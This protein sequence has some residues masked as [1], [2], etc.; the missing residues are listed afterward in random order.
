MALTVQEARALLDRLPRAKLGYFPTPLMRLDRLSEKLGVTVYIKRDDCSGVNLFGG[1]KVRKLEYL[2]GQALRDGATHAVTYGATQSNHAMETAWAC[3][4]LGIQPILYLTAVV[5][6]RPEEMRANL[7]LDHIL[8][9]EIHIVPIEPGETEAD[10]EARSFEMGAAR[11]AQLSAAGSVCADIPMGGASALGSV[12]FAA[13]MAELRAQ[14]DAAGLRFSRIYHSTGTGGTMAGLHAGRAMLGMDDTQIVS[15][16]AS[17]KD[18]SAYIEKVVGLTRAALELIGSDAAPD[19]E[20]MRVNLDQW[21]PGYERPSAAGSDA[22]RL[23]ARTEGLFVDPVYTGK[24]L[25]G[26]LA[27]VERGDIRPGECVLFWHTGGAT[28]LFAEPEIL[29]D[30]T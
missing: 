26:L 9:A 20:A 11:A 24:A 1:N 5:P 17:P 6:P 28:A 18:E 15:V 21:R 14:A 22:I 29:G 30:V 12:G 19:R 25:A 16:A 7:L 27:D 13:A 3:R 8:G 4:R 10:A 23:L 2:L